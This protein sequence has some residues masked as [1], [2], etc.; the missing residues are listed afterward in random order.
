MICIFV[1]VTQNRHSIAALLIV[2]VNPNIPG[3]VLACG[4][5]CH[6]EIL[7][8]LPVIFQKKHKQHFEVSH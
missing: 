2:A 3:F 8:Y 6:S 4:T 7:P 5:D 1:K